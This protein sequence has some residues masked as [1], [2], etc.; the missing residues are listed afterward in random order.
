MRRCLPAP[1]NM[2]LACAVCFILLVVILVSVYFGKALKEKLTPLIS[3]AGKIQSQE[4]G[5]TVMASD[6][7]E[8]GDVLNAID[9]MR[10]A[11]E[12]SLESQWKS[13]QAQKEQILALAHDLKTPLTLVR[14]NAELLSGTGLTE[15]QEELTGYICKS[16]LQMQDYVQKLLDITR[17]GYKLELKEVPARSFLDSITGQAEN[18]CNASNSSF[19]KSLDCGGQYFM[20]DKEELARAF[21]NIFSNAA[22]HTPEG[23]TIYF[24]AFIE[25]NFIIFKTT[26]TGRGFSEEA[27][28]NAKKQFYMDDKSRNSKKHSGI[29][30]YMAEQVIKQHNGE[31]VLGN[32]ARTGGAEVLVKIPCMKI[33]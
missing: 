3:A 24:E 12:E 7:K 27:L 22:E 30:L 33:L 31:L 29:G 32:S 23:G 19:Q 26:D 1:Q 8:I 6:I 17:H 21:L 15:E 4:L 18:L 14:G 20:A 10:A 25:N 5:F 2:L 13:E 11:L 16:S 28:K 9:N